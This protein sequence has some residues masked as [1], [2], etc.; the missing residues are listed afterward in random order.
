[1]SKEDKDESLIAH[2]EALRSTLI[3]CLSAIG[4]LLPFCFYFSPKVLD[5]LVKTLIGKNNIILN[6]F[7]P[8]E[9]F[10]LQIKLA[11]LMAA[12]IAFPYIAK[13]LWDFVLPALL[14]KE[15]LFIRKIVVSSSILFSSGT[16]FCLFVILPIIMNFGISFSSQ[17]VQAVF[18][19]SNVI[20]LA[21]WLSFVFGLMFQIPLVTHILIKLDFVSYESISN[22]RPYV[23]TALLIISALLTP[24]DII[25][26]ILLFTPTYLLFELGLIFS[27]GLKNKPEDEQPE[28]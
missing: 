16:I 2:L 18:G 13:N 24:P 10:V 14:D 1:M 7:T 21:L 8:M 27:R 20:N 23:V 11:L 17:N 3:K 19:I 25:S 15:K 9:V 12:I 4:I 22:K 28:A 6:Y 26:Q 5:F